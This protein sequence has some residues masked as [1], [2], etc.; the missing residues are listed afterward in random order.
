MFCW[1]FWIVGFLCS[2]DCCIVLVMAS[3]IG[4]F[5]FYAEDC[6]DGVVILVYGFLCCDM[7]PPLLLIICC[8]PSSIHLV[9]CGA[10]VPSGLL[11][12]VMLYAGMLELP[13]MLLREFLV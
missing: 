10:Y 2:L 3:Q 8:L 4:D 5:H 7:P 6:C 13:P 1:E 12:L 9:L 11:D